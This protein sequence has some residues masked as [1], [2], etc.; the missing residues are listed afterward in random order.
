[1]LDEI[2]NYVQ[3]LQRQVE[4]WHNPVS[5]FLSIFWWSPISPVHHLSEVIQFHWQLCLRWITLCF[6]CLGLL[7]KDASFWFFSISFN[8]AFKT[9]N[10]ILLTSNSDLFIWNLCV[11]LLSWKFFFQF[12]SMK[13]AT[14]NPRLDVSI[15][16]LLAKDVSGY[17]FSFLKE[18]LVYGSNGQIFLCVQMCGSV[19][20]LVLLSL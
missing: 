5:L 18:E 11:F 4:V 16:G 7:W 6:L 2:I 10:K 17:K 15:E 9:Q 19:Y 8:C 14:V 12:L 3:S 1:M 13:L 20:V